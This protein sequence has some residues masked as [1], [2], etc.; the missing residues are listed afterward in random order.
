MQYSQLAKNC[1]KAPKTNENSQ[2]GNQQE[3]GK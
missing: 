3:Q 2:S 1:P